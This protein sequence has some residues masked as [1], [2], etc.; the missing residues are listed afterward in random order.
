[1]ECPR[2]GYETKRAGRDRNILQEAG[3]ISHRSGQH[4]IELDQQV[5]RWQQMWRVRDCKAIADEH[6]VFV[7]VRM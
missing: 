6:V 2:I 1:M 5:V 4:K 7:V 3:K